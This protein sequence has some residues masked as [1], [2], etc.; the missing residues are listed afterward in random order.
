MTFSAPG[1]ARLHDVM[2]AHVAEQRVPGVVT[3]L[4]RRGELQV[5][6]VGALAFEGKPMKRDTL[7][8]ITSMTKPMV[9]AAAMTLVESCKLRLDEPVDD[10][11][12]ELANRKVLR[13]LESPLDDV[14]PAKRAI[15]LRDLL[16][17]RMGFGMIFAP[18]ETPI[19]KAIAE[20]KTLSVGPPK[21]RTELAPDEWMRRLG[22]LPWMHQPGE[23]WLYNTSGMVLGVL[24]ARATGK[25]LEELLRASLFE[26]LGMNDTSFVVSPEQRARFA[27]SYFPN[28]KT[29]VLE[30]HDEPDGQW[31]VPP[32]FPD[33]AAGLV[34][35]V[36]DCMAFGRMMLGKGTYEGRRVLSRM[37]VETMTSDQLPASVKAS[38]KFFFE[39]WE[40]RTW[41]FGLQIIT[42]RDDLP[43]SPGAYGWDGGYGTAWQTDPREDFVTLLLTQRAGFP[44]RNPIYRD[45][46]T[47]AY[48]AIE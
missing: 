14:V 20:T 15:T 24:L 11:L 38:S 6:C 5:D 40:R 18:P 42:E 17:Y 34:S 25:P 32:S 43:S 29:S 4:Y 9:A 36:D 31:S 35:T 45:F 46:R 21:P 26:P 37:S 3:A 27:T 22:S 19:L 13:T 30:V 48:A 12:P 41:G 39:P 28:P 33:A 7:F 47:A 23:G 1:L 44:E 8:R 2:S 16:S 10:L